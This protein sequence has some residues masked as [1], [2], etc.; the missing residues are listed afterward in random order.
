MWCGV[1][2]PLLVR[3][4]DGRAE[5]IGGPARGLLLAALISRVGRTVSP[6][7]LIDDL[8]GQ[9]P[10][11]SAAKTLQSHIVRLRD[12]LGRGEAERILV[13]DRAGYRL[14]LG[15]DELD[16]ACFERGMRDAQNMCRA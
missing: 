10:P 1:L 2:G 12:D 5:T 11:R 8:W 15:P 13:T 9:V 4:V 14:L 6:D 7:V 3:R 16:V